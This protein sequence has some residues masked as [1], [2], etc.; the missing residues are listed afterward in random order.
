MT[1]QDKLAQL[2]PDFARLIVKLMDAVKARG[3]E[4]MI[5]Q[6]LRTFEEQNALYAK[7]RTK[8]G[9]KVTNAKGG[10]SHHNYGLAVDLC[11]K[12]KVNGSHFPDPHP[13]WDIIG[14]EAMKLG[15]EWGGGWKKFKDRPHVQAP[16]ELAYLKKWHPLVGREGVWAR[17]SDLLKARGGEREMVA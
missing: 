9:P 12:E 2:Q 17:V 6:G 11:L 5:T 14:E 8:P 3:H 16:V 7:G 13:V 15:L 1:D 10:E 4:L